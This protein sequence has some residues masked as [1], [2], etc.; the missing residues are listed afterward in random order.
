MVF[1]QVILEK[2][3]QPI[4][5]LIKA[6]N[7]HLT[8][9]NIVD[10]GANVGFASIFFSHEFSDNFILSLEPEQKNFEAL[11][12]NIDQNN[13]SGITPVQA[14]I[15][16]RDKE[17]TLNNSFRDGREWSISLKEADKNSKEQLKINGY[18]LITLLTKH[19]LERVDFL[20]ID[21]EGGEK[22]IFDEW[23]HDNSVFKFIKFIA[24]EIHD[25]IADRDFINKLLI[26]NGFEIT[27]IG[28]TTFGENMKLA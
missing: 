25:E 21:I 10:A 8:K 15:W 18:S 26:N 6:R 19:A 13:L 24:I 2:E 5:D 3:Y 27:E 11:V 28:E 20:K 12:E 16:G 17:M 1:D 23:A 7:K 4:V 9:L 14:G 22:Y